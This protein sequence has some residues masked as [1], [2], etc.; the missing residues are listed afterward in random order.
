MA[1]YYIHARRWGINQFILLHEF[2][3]SSAQNGCELVSRLII[4]SGPQ[5]DSST[6]ISRVPRLGLLV[7]SGDVI[8]SHSC[9]CWVWGRD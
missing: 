2:V 4:V 9:V 1:Y 8:Y 5:T 3:Q 7:H 6:T